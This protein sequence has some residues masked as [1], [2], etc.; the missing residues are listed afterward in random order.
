MP[1]D[2]NRSGFKIEHR[3]DSSDARVSFDLDICFS[4]FHT[5]SHLINLFRGSILLEDVGGLTYGFI[6]SIVISHLTTPASDSHQ[7][8]SKIRH[9]CH[10][11]FEGGNPKFFVLKEPAQLHS[12]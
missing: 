2:N 7:Y 12:S 1:P 4:T 8:I 6:Y 11:F 5:K 3:T 9:F 10:G